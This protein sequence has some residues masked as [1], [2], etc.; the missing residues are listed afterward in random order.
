MTDSIQ[1]NGSGNV[2]VTSTGKVLL[3]SSSAPNI[4]SLNVTPTTSAQTITAS[5]SVDGYSP[6]NVS[7]VTS[8]ID[9]NI[10][11]GNIKKD[12]VILG[13][14]GTYEGSG[15]GSGDD[16]YA[17]YI[18]IENMIKGTS[19]VEADEVEAACDDISMFLYGTLH[20]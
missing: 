18:Q 13:V 6:I 7:A 8:S 10:S 9:Q 20:S 1:T 15:E 3:N 14:T 17:N 4:E 12:I 11:A 5:G 16:E 2:Y 19:Y